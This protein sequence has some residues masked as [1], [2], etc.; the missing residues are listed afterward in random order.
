MLDLRDLNLTPK[1][2]RVFEIFEKISEI[3]R[4]SGDRI[5]I[6]DYCEGF[7]EKLNLKY[8]RDNENNVIIFKPA[9]TGFENS[10]PI[11]LQGHLDIVCQKTIERNIDFTSDPLKI[12]REGDFIKAEGTTLGAD[13]GIAVALIMAILESDDIVHPPIEAVFT[14]DE[15]IG[16]LG[17]TALDKSILISTHDESV[18]DYMRSKTHIDILEVK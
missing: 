16:L 15:E 14:A 8:Y 5:K 18:I 13:N 17:A 1:T 2:H 4:G 10:Q 11:I 3:P 9:S 7:A 12:Y 6:A